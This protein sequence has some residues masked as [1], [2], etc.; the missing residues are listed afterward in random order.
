M[1]PDNRKRGG[2]NW[3]SLIGWIIFILVIAGGPLFNLLRSVL[4]GAIALPA[5]LSGLLP[6]AIGG[7]VV[8]S[9]I[10]SAVRALGGGNRAGGAPRLPTDM[11]GS[12]RPPNAPMPPFGNPRGPL[13]PPSVPAP[14]AFSLPSSSAPRQRLPASRFDPVISPAVVAVGIIGLLVLGGAALFFL[15]QGGP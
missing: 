6:I 13:R 3:S 1:R 2:V 8:L 11:S 7:L 10:V 4:G 12:S 5:N 15:A 9:I 14:R